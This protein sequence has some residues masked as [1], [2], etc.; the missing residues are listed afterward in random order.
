MNSPSLY[1]F[2]LNFSSNPKVKEASRSYSLGIDF[3]NSPDFSKGSK[4]EPS[5]NLNLRLENSNMRLDKG[6]ALELLGL[7]DEIKVLSQSE[8]EE[9]EDELKKKTLEIIEGIIENLSPSQELELVKE[10]S[11]QTEIEIGAQYPHEDSEIHEKYSE[12]LFDLLRKAFRLSV[13]SIR[14]LGTEPSSN[15]LRI[16]EEIKRVRLGISKLNLENLQEGK[17]YPSNEEILNFPSG[18]ELRYSN[19]ESI[20]DLYREIHDEI[21]GDFYSASCEG[22]EI[23]NLKLVEAKLLATSSLIKAFRKEGLNELIIESL[24]YI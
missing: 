7:F 23:G 2:S 11:S 5:I 9:R 18:E 14:R 8:L 21:L 15:D 3:F 1:S 17:P 4:I 20:L 10:L 16:I 12:L 24:S 22:E 19:H 6:G 13:H